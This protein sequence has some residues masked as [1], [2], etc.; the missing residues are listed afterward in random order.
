MR[1]EALPLGLAEGSWLLHKI[2][3][4]SMEHVNVSVQKQV[5]EG[6]KILQE[7][8]SIEVYNKSVKKA[9]R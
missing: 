9:G 8:G 6:E 5:A 4:A 7:A 2:S 1:L 3:P